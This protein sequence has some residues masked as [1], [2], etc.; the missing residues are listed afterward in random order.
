MATYAGQ[1][2]QIDLTAKSWKTVPISDADVQKWL[3][4][5]GFAAKLFYDEMDAGLDALDPAS[6]LLVFNGVLTGTF[7]PTAARSSWCGR[8]PLTGIWNEANLGGHWGAELRFAGYDGLVITGRA[9]KPVYLWINGITSEIELRDA[10]HVWGKDYFVAADTLLAETDARAQVAG[11]GQAGENLVKISGVMSGASDYVRTAARGGMGAVLGSKNLKAIVVRG[12][13]RPQYTD[14]TAFRT[15]VKTQNAHLKTVPPTRALSE[16]G[17]AGGTEG[18]ELYSDLPLKNWSA[19]SWEAVTRVGGSALYDNYKVK[20]TF[21]FA[22]PI[23]CGK[24]VENPNGKYAAPRGEGVEYETI[25]G[26]GG[27]TQVDDIEAVILANSLCNRYGLDTISASS[28]I[29]FGMEAFERGIIGTEETGGL[30]LTFG[31]ADAMVAM[32]E[33][34]ALRQDIG[35]TLAEGVRAAA[36][37]LGNGAA[38]FAV[39]VKGMEVP[40]HDPRAFTSM[41]VNYATANRGACHLESLSYWNGYGVPLPGLGYTDI[42]PAHESTPAQA[43]L[44]YDYQN[45]VSVYNPLG[46]CKFIVKGHLGPETIVKFLRDALGW[47]WDTADLLTV[48]ERLFQLKRLINRR[49]G[50]SAADDVLPP[51]L[52]SEPRPDGHA[53]GVLP[54]MDVMLP[55]YYRLRGWDETGAPTPERLQQVGLG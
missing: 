16:L 53:A 14:K 29:A 34:I 15:E 26:F 40:Y 2:L 7:A 46:L 31:N 9:E 4:G 25:A 50:I 1:Y 19:G 45:Y 47:E 33:K 55:E 27:M 52:Q 42:V 38:D 21:C 18:A 36:E 23:G 22:C 3:L 10:G 24:E 35:D 54:Q 12:K 44:A 8:S 30:A 48:G 11:I 49:Y 32:V 51:R 43:K 37:K 6:P 28:V 13:N 20:D 17:T 39:H 5:S 41:A